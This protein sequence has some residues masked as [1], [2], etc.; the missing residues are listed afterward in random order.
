[1]EWKPRDGEEKEQQPTRG[2]KNCVESH[3]IPGGKHGGKEEQASVRKLSEVPKVGD[4]QR[5]RNG[6]HEEAS[7]V[8]H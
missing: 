1:M 5:E 2:E 6:G 3:G 7:Q 8:S 4:Q